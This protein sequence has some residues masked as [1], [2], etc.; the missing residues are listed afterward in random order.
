MSRYFQYFPKIKYG[1]KVMTDITKNV[2]LLDD[3]ESDPY[4]FLPYTVK[5]EESPE[6]VALYY[7]ES[8]DHVW[9]VYASNKIV[10]PYFQWP[11]S[12]SVLE[13]TI[14]K[15]YKAQAEQSMG[16]ELSPQGVLQWTQNA[17]T[18]IY[19]NI[20]YYYNNEGTKITVDTFRNGSTNST[21]TASDW[22][23]MRIYD[24]ELRL[25]EEK[26]DILLLNREYTK[27]A[28]RNLRRVLNG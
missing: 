7:Y 23:A 27:I 12:N 17:S 4:A 10:D 3:I 24:E 1:D 20:V 21:I 18:S 13:K 16:V 28:T 15:K 26:R 5:D 14:Q 9:L 8:V 2:R 19:D 25:N 6:E 22:T 11:M